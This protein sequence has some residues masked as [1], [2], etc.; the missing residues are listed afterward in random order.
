MSILMKVP[1]FQDRYAVSNT[2]FYR[3][4]QAGRLRLTKIGR[5]SRV[6]QTDAEAWLAS[7]ST[8]GGEGKVT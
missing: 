1:A 2:T 3:E 8:V 4:V 7:L 5:S 6:S